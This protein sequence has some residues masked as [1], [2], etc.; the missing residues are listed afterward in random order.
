M[1]TSLTELYLE[2]NKIGNNDAAILCESLKE[3]T[4]LTHLYLGK[5]GRL[6]NNDIGEEGG[7]QFLSMLEVNRT[8]MKIEFG[9]NKLVKTINYKIQRVIEVHRFEP[10][11]TIALRYNNFKGELLSSVKKRILNWCLK[12]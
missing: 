6:G 2:G 5:D 9:S 11:L 4:C 7:K 3:N 8:I 1:K 10:A 12:T